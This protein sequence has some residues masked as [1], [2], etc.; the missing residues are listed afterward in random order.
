[1]RTLSPQTRARNRRWLLLA[2]CASAFLLAQAPGA[3]GD[4]IN[5]ARPTITGKLEVGQTLTANPGTWTDPTSRI[6]RYEYAWFDCVLPGAGEDC[7]ATPLGQG[8]QLTIPLELDGDATSLTVVAIDELGKEGFGFSEETAVITD[9]IPRFTV[10]EAVSGGGSLTG[11]ANGQTGAYENLNLDCPGSC[12]EDSYATGTSIEFV[13]HPQPGATFLGWGGGVCSGT[14]LTCSFVVSGN[15]TVT[16]AFTP[17]PLTN[18]G[19][20]PVLEGKEADAPG[21][22]GGLSAD[23]AAGRAGAFGSEGEEAPASLVGRLPARLVSLRA[24]RGGDGRLQATVTCQQTKACHLVLAVSSGA[25]GARLVASR[26]LT[27][28]PG[29]R[30]S[31]SL[32]LNHEG[33]RLLARRRRLPVSAHLMLREGGRSVGVGGA[34]LTLTA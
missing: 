19:P 21:E 2:S 30:A 24:Q 22:S 23:G 16:A 10:S 14:A 8:D 1:M 17:E 15:E 26:T 5:T 28:A 4:P 33:A 12:G 32:A 18:G 27:L 11:A 25:P 34:R 9:D 29:Q 3:L 13:A 31:I 20:L 6:V 7:L